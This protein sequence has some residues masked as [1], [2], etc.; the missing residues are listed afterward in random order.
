MKELVTTAVQDEGLYRHFG[1][2]PK[3]A[4]LY[5]CDPAAIINVK[6]VESSDQ[7]RGEPLKSVD[8]YWSWWDFKKNRFEPVLTWHGLI[9]LDI[10]FPA[11]FKVSEERGDGKAYRVNVERI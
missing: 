10:C 2:H 1:I 6:L 9:L 11:G 4:S 3:T 8:G 7:S 5:G